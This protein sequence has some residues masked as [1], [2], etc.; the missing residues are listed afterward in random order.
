MLVRPKQAVS[1][2]RFPN[3]TSAFQRIQLSIARAA[4]SI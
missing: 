4:I 2:K 1:M 3:W